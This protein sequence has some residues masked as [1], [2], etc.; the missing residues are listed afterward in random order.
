M[1]RLESCSCGQLFKA[2]GGCPNPGCKRKPFA[3]VKGPGHHGSE[4]R[5][6]A[7]TKRKRAFLALP[8]NRECWECGSPASV[9]DHIIPVST[10]EGKARLMDPTNWRPH[11]RQCSARQGAR[12]G[13]AIAARN[14]AN[15]KH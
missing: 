5:A 4:W 13:S 9:V 11:C 10:P 6:T 15:G 1:A 3:S 7:A 2:G 8:H 12:L 14:R